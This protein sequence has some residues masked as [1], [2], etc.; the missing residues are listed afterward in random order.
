MVL[1]VTK[2]ARNEDISIVKPEY[3]RGIQPEPFAFK[4]IDG[5]PSIVDKFS[6][7]IAKSTRAGT[8]ESLKDEEK[9]RLLK[10]VYS[11]VPSF[12]YRELVSQIKSSYNK[13]HE[14]SVGDNQAK[15]FITECKEKKW[16]LQKTHKGKYILSSSLEPP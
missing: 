13:L 4:I 5:L 14:E 7:K 16:I 10:D 11:D 2:Q 1:S 15:S 12:M 9:Q 3:S 6:E 8:L